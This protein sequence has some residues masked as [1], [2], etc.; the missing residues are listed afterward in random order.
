[1]F[2][3]RVLYDACVLYPAPLRSL[4]I[5]LAQAGLVVPRW[6]DAIHEEWMR[7]LIRDKPDISRAKVERVRDLM[8]AAVPDCVVTG[9]EKRIDA[10]SLPDADDRHVLAAAIHCGAEAIVTFNLSDFPLDTLRGL[11]IEAIHPDE[12]L[13]GLIAAAPSVVCSAVRTQRASLR[14][15]PMTA[16][17]LLAVFE[18]Q[19]LPRAVSLLRQ[20]IVD[21]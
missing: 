13:V 16:E 17:E 19:G 5:Y 18:R 8:N 11:G 21:L 10:L 2:P 6:T 7:N 15:P 20:F 14:N 12:L 4:L 9:Y 3:R 1:M